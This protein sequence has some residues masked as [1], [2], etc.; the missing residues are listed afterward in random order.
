MHLKMWIEGQIVYLGGDL[1]KHLEGDGEVRLVREGASKECNVN[2][3]TPVDH[4][5]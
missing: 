4:G 1:I 2:Q 5:S 3:V